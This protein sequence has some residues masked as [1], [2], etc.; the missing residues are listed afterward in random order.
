MAS[1]TC[2]GRLTW[3]RRNN[4]SFHIDAEKC[5]GCGACAFACLFGVPQPVDSAKS[6]YIIDEKLC[7][8][9]GQCENICPTGAISP[10]AGYKKI[11]AVIINA[12]RCNGC[13]KCYDA[14]L[15][16]APEG[17]KDKPPFIINTEKCFNCGLCK[18]R[19]EQV[20]ISFEYV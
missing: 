14:C 10:G 9:C 19:C 6:K 11:R 15:A 8:S 13:A 7:N 3:E 12:A 18:D 20:A 2:F 17:V 1:L 5:H 16:K 4:M